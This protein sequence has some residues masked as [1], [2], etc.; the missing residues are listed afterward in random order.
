MGCTVS[1]QEQAAIAS[2]SA[3]KNNNVVATSSET[4]NTDDSV[5]SH[6]AK[7]DKLTSQAYSTS[8]PPNHWSDAVF[9][10]PHEWLRHEMNA[11]EQSAAALPMDTNPEDAWKADL[12]A[13]WIT[14]FFVKVIEMHHDNEEQIYMPFLLEKGAEIP[15]DKIAHDHEAL[16]EE[17]KKLDAVAN[18]IVQK[19]GL[20]CGAAIAN[21][22]SKVPKLVQHLKGKWTPFLLLFT[23][24]SYAVR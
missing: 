16:I 2:A 15:N 11:M 24:S 6:V 9:L 20:H 3:S 17:L 21:L 10:I 22:K 5:P 1:K 19:K 4:H 13:Q 8:H 14:T 23:Q 7:M 18:D 12:F